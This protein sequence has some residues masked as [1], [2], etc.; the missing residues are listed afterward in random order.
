MNGTRGGLTIQFSLK[1]LML[2]IVISALLVIVHRERTRSETMSELSQVKIE[3]YSNRAAFEKRLAGAVQLIDF[4]DID[5]SKR[6]VV[7][8]RSLRYKHKGVLM[9]SPGGL[10]VG[11]TFGFPAQYPPAS[12]TNSLAP[13]PQGKNPGGNK[14]ELTF[15]AGGGSGLVAGIGVTFV[16]AD[17][18]QMGASGIAAFG[19]DD[20]ILGKETG[21]K[22]PDGGTAFRGLVAV[23]AVGEVIPA[24]S[25]VQ[26]TNGTGW[27]GVDAGDGVTLDD[28]VFGIPKTTVLR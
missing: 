27:P 13:G 6:D 25:R 21:F 24:I 11:R 15:Q 22:T 20:R 3:V 18:P 14:T 28:L 4:D 2:L 19:W 8:I 23:N 17:H 1:T 9:K 5:T 7:A 12:G 10:F 26:I 16:D